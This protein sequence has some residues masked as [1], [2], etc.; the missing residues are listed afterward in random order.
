MYLGASQAP[1]S[2]VLGARP[3]IWE[4]HSVVHQI[5]I[6]VSD[7]I[8]SI[9]DYTISITTNTRILLEIHVRYIHVTIHVQYSILFSGTHCY[10]IDFVTGTIPDCIRCYYNIVHQY[11]SEK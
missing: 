11:L 9:A 1:N 3:D 10:I 8:C 7:T 4:P 5:C 6:S 2:K